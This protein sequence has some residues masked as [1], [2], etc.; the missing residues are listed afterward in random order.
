MVA[1]SRLGVSKGRTWARLLAASL[2]AASQA[3][4][5]MLLTSNNESVYQQIVDQ[6]EATLDSLAA[7]E[8][9]CTTD[10]CRADVQARRE[11]AER[12]HADALAAIEDSRRNS[13]EY[14]GAAA[15]RMEVSHA[16]A[17][18]SAQRAEVENAALIVRDFVTA[19][20]RLN[21]FIA[22]EEGW[23]DR[24]TTDDGIAFSV[25][26]LSDLTAGLGGLVVGIV[27]AFQDLFSE[28]PVEAAQR[29]R[30][31]IIVN[32]E[33]WA[34]ELVDTTSSAV[35]TLIAEDANLDL[36]EFDPWYFERIRSGG[37]ELFTAVSQIPARD[38]DLQIE[39]VAPQ[40]ISE[41]TTTKELRHHLE[42][43]DTFATIEEDLTARDQELAA[44]VATGTTDERTNN[45]TLQATLAAMQALAG[46]S[47]Q[48]LEGNSEACLGVL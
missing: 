14:E 12:L 20:D 28:S 40:F 27:A 26:I 42:Y 17:T 10:A 16:L 47:Q 30:R 2:L 35:D 7:E 1:E 44:A 19:L 23:R 36:V 43:V 11:E 46:E 37:N 29:M 6:Y 32:I 41:A 5:M 13:Q 45:T 48:N 21:N 38:R 22:A 8:A 31:E 39:D 9:R 34:K 15:E 33:Y 3:G 25:G 24:M 18:V 4:C